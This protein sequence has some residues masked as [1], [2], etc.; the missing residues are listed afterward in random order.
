MKRPFSPLTCGLCG[1]ERQ[2]GYVTF[3][4]DDGSGVIVIREVPVTICGQCGEEWI[5]DATAIELERLV[6]D[7]RLRGAQVEVVRMS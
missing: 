5:D 6:A 7:A 3:T 2:P 1:G 4:V